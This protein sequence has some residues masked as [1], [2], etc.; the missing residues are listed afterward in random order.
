ME[1]VVVHAPPARHVVIAVLL[2]WGV[3]ELALR[4]A[5]RGGRR[6]VDPSMLALG[7][8]IAAGATLGFRAA[9]APPG[10]A[11]IG[12]GW[13]AVITGV[14]LM[15]IGIGLRLW[16]IFTL[17]RFFKFQVVIQEGHR[18]VQTG[19]YRRIRHPS[20]TGT[21]IAFLGAGVA[22]GSWLSVLALVLVPLAGFLV[23]IRVEEAALEDALGEQYRAYAARTRRLVPGVW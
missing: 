12:G 1:S 17:G 14:L 4:L 3:V 16:A 18:V 23:R 20:Y 7:A 6:A 13:T 22:L 11:V 21:L 10:W 5:N 2:G 8:A 15:V 19:P 9:V